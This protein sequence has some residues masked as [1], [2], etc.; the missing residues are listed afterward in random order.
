MSCDTE[1]TVLGILEGA[2]RIVGVKS[3]DRA[4]SKNQIQEA[5]ALLNALLDEFASESL[6]IAYDDLLTFNLVDGQRDYIIS[7]EAGAD[8]T[9]NKLVRLKYVWLVK[10]GIQYPINIVDDDYFYGRYVNLSIKARPNQVFL[11]NQV[12]KTTLTFLQIPD[13]AYECGIKG[14]F[15]LDNLTSLN[16]E[17]TTLPKYY[18]LFLHFALAKLLN[19]NLPGTVFSVQ[20]EDQYK[21]RLKNLQSTNDIDL[22]TETLSTLNKKYFG[23]TYYKGGP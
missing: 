1:Q 10:D 9:A 13:F 8:V 12:S 4:L 18:Y 17:I 14:K 15:V 20:D 23:S 3:D 6:L 21:N 2:Y 16:T 7:Q 5:L 11:Q 19:A 22:V